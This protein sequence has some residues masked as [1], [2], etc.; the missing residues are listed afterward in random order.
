MVSIKL[1]LKKKANA[2]GEHSIVLQ[3][4]KD[5]RKKILS[6]GLSVKNELWDENEHCF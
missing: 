4:L 5:R 3:V 1:K 6:T 2:E